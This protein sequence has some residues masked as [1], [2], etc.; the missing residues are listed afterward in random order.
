LSTIELLNKKLGA[1]FLTTGQL[2]RAI[3]SGAIAVNV[4][5]PTRDHVYPWPIPIMPKNAPAGWS[6]E[7]HWVEQNFRPGGFAAAGAGP[8][9]SGYAAQPISGYGTAS[10]S[11]FAEDY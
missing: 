7:T 10:S 6:I 9:S 8:S 4:G 5:C 1:H 3:R 11:G 2:Y